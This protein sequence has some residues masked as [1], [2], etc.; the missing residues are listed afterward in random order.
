ML[1]TKVELMVENRPAYK[2][3]LDGLRERTIHGLQRERCPFQPQRD[4]SRLDGQN[5][6][7]QQDS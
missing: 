5:P 6:Y 7:K 3:K 4:R 2:D 1:M